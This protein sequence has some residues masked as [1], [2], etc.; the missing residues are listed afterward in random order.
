MIKGIA[1]TM[2][3]VVDMVRA[4]KFYEGALGLIATLENPDGQWVEYEPGGRFVLTTLAPVRP[5]SDAGG[6]VAFV[7]DDLAALTQDLR[8]KGVVVR[9]DLADTP[10]FLM[11]IVMDPEGNAVTLCQPK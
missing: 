11:S 2:Y 8:N 10:S 3:P 5:A 9:L 6:N 4:R 1:Y 7:V